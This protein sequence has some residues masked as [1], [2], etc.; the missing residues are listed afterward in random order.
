MSHQELEV[1]EVVQHQPVMVA[2]R[3]LAHLVGKMLEVPNLQLQRPREEAHRPLCLPCVRPAEDKEKWAPQ[4]VFFEE[5]E[6]R[7]RLLHF[8]KR[9]VQVG[10]LADTLHAC[11]YLHVCLLPLFP[12]PARLKVSLPVDHTVSALEQVVVIDLVS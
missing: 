7:L 10:I 4:R 6:P 2:A 3:E 11:L 5:L 1:S 8:W 9:P 12:L